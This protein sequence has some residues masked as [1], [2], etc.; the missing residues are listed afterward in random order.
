MIP[1]SYLLPLH[2]IN[3]VVLYA[4]WNCATAGDEYGIATG[5][6]QP[7]HRVFY[8]NK[9][10]GCT[11]PD[12]KHQPVKLPNHWNSMKK[13]GECKIPNITVS[14]LRPGDGVWEG[15]ERRTKKHGPPG[16][17]RIVIPFI[18]PE[19]ESESVQFSVVMLALSLV[20]LSFRFKATVHLSTCL[21]DQSTGQ[22]FDKEQLIKQ[23]AYTIDNTSMKVSPDMLNETWIDYLKRWFGV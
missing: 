2:T 1:A 15:Y 12:E 17:S 5:R 16:R 23:Y 13:A 14:P 11:I 4:P 19:E 7:Q 3:D 6:I 10:E 8:C 21:C 20:L 9:D 22:K 18:L